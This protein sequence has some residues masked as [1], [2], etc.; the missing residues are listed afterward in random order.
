MICKL[1]AL[2][3]AFA[4]IG[5]Q[6]TQEPQ[7]AG[8]S[9]KIVVVVGT[10]GESEY[11]TAFRE[12][13]NQWK[14]IADSQRMTSTMIGFDLG[15]DE[16]TA[17]D[18]TDRSQLLNSLEIEQNDTFDEI[19]I[20]LIGHGTY[21]GETAKF[22]LRGP[23]I[24]A[25]DLK[26]ALQPLR[27]RVVIINCASCSGPFLNALSAPNRVV[28][29]ATQSGAQYSFSRFGKYF[30]SFVNDLTADLDKDGQ[31][32]V[33]EA[34]IA[35]SAGVAEFYDS[36]KRLA[37]ELALIDD[38]GDQRGTPADWF[39]GVR[40]VKKAKNGAVDGPL[41]NRIFLVRSDRETNLDPQIRQQRDELETQVE[42]LRTQKSSM[43]ETEYYRQLEI[44]MVQIA[45]LTR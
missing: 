25:N 17:E 8:D 31:T 4:G 6:S 38:N 3:I 14:S 28:V 33:L 32:S 42:R 39:R 16:K 27:A 23:D 41:S 26:R 18:L 13:G 21:D 5:G 29:T 37:S 20:V 19:W 15:K 34:F 11:A 22:N 40:A 12:W 44:L 36:E 43:D 1:T 2:L 24:S 9:R 45:R 10:P 30:A 7:D 35:A